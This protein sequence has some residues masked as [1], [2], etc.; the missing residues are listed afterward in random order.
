M[1]APGKAAVNF[2]NP[3]QYAKQG[4]GAIPNIALDAL[5]IVPE[6]GSAAAS[7]IRG[8]VSRGVLGNAA[9][10]AQKSLLH[11]AEANIAHAEAPAIKQL[12]THMG[13]HFEE[14]IK[15]MG[16]HKG[17]HAMSGEHGDEGHDEASPTIFAANIKSPFKGMK[18]FKTGGWLDNYL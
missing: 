10:Q 2:S 3:E 17:V 8:G 5:A 13:E 15:H 1:S 18:A 7:T 9:S 6:L 4:W 16:A 11:S 14:G 12:A